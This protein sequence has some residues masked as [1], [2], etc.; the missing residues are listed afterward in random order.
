M[1]KEQ[2][3]LNELR[4]LV[5]SELDGTRM[6]D[7]YLKHCD[8]L[9]KLVD[10]ATPKKTKEIEENDIVAGKILNFNCPECNHNLFVVFKD[11]NRVAKYKSNY[12]ER[13]GQALDWSEED[14]N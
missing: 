4:D 13:C 12:C 14:D 7:E 9:Q 1:N 11:L 3:S 2:Q 8:I 5:H 10:K 6:L